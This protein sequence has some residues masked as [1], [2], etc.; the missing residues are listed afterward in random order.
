MILVH[1]GSY[2]T[3]KNTL[4]IVSFFM[5]EK[6][7][8]KIIYQYSFEVQLKK[9]QHLYGFFCTQSKDIKIKIT[10]PILGGY[11][12]PEKLEF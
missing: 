11:T 6:A 5:S 8:K 7:N 1:K 12:M 4:A 10:K 9:G 3:E 2:S